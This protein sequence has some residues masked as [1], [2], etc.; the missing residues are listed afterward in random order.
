MKNLIYI[1]LFSLTI[2]A[3]AQSPAANYNFTHQYVV[4]VTDHRG[5]ENTMAYYLPANGN[6]IGTN[7]ER[8]SSQKR[9]T[10]V[11]DIERKATFMFMKNKESKTLWSSNL[12]FTAMVKDATELKDIQVEATNET[13]K[14]LGYT[15]KKYNVTGED[16][17]AVVW[18]TQDTP[19]NLS[20]KV[21][22]QL[23]FY[24]FINKRRMDYGNDQ[25]EYIEALMG[26]TMK[27]VNTDTSKRNPRVTTWEC[28]AFEP[29]SYNI[30][31]AEYE[32]IRLLGR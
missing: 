14:I 1:V 20:E 16:M 29:Y 28:V 19:V 23:S 13:E 12:D 31:S 21:I 30:V 18:V 26:L 27:I 25:S 22:Y 10:T 15:C 32:E 7:T 2:Q 17:H 24:R 8:V 5:R 9:I 4:E 3:N 6:Y 11:I